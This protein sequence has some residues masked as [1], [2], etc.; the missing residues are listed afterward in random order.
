M[1]KLLE[2]GCNRNLQDSDGRT[3]LHY[4]AQRGVGVNMLLNA[5]RK[6][7]IVFPFINYNY[8]ENQINQK[9]S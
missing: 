6:E 3:A 2:D 1:R 5:G 7:Q 8:I 4:A 9:K